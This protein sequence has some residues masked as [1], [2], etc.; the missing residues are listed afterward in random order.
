MFSF[1]A[2]SSAQ[3]HMNMWRF[4]CLEEGAAAKAE[5][6][7]YTV[8]AN[9]TYPGPSI[10]IQFVDP[11]WA[12]PVGVRPYPAG[13]GSGGLGFVSAIWRKQGGP[14]VVSG[15][16]CGRVVDQVLFLG[17]GAGGL[18]GP[19]FVSETWSGRNGGLVS[20]TWRGQVVDQVL[21]PVCV[22]AVGGW[23][24]LSIGNLRKP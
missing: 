15:M 20:A 4:M 14:G 24:A 5:P 6:S 7:A 10:I 17:L 23:W 9:Q 3:T 22:C 11:F 2:S 18:V 12:I 8:I 16:C 19:G 21:F 13:A 1:R